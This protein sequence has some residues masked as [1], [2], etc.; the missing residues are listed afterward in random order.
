MTHRNSHTQIRP[1]AIQQVV[2]TIDRFGMFTPGEKVLVGVSGG[3]D[4]MMLLHTLVH[5][6]PKYQLNLGVA[7][8]NHG[9]RPVS[10]DQDEAFVARSAER[11]DLPFFR[12]RLNL[13]LQTGSVEEQAR[14]ARYGFFKKVMADHGYTKIALGH[15][16]NDN[17]EAVLMHL[18]RGSGIRG[19]AGIPP[20]RGNRIVRPLID[21]DRTA[22]I[23]YLKDHQIHFTEDETN[24]DPV[25][26]R[27]R[28]RHHLLPMLQKTYNPNIIE[29][30]HRT[31]DVCRE[32]DIWIDR[33][34]APHLDPIIARSEK[35]C[36]ELHCNLLQSE[37]L[38][39]QRR[40]IRRAIRIWH[41]HLKRMGV[42]HIDAIIGL[43]A[44]GGIGKRIS[45]PNGIEAD[46]PAAYLRLVRCNGP[47]AVKLSEK[48]GFCHTIATPD[49]LPEAIILPEC[50]CRLLFGIGKPMQREQ[51]VSKDHK[52]VC[53]DLDKLTFPLQIRSFQPGDRIRPFGMQGTQKIKKLFIDRKIPSARRHKIP[54]LES[55][56]SIV[57][58]AGI[59]R[60]N[61]AEISGQTKRVLQ[62]TID[63]S[64]ESA[65]DQ[66]DAASENH[67]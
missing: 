24:A 64:P 62:V 20:V 4:S 67:G 28:I 17:A 25:Y 35:H 65:M 29:T 46:R 39:V 32:E 54:L 57:W 42:H 18:L 45:L 51:W 63:V 5:L 1:P 7:H 47:N 2:R 53:F 14:E 11:F 55:Q 16:K 10:A 40:L 13:R 43:L 15:Q 12:H 66:C 3:P 30:L 56:G 50:G 21:L 8:L 22:I 36:L 37:P 27:N 38:A 49:S 33:H 59:R 26:E 41:G 61:L 19:L 58:V 48:M 31:A 44:K 34:L 60:S 9:L 6:A 23:G 52:R